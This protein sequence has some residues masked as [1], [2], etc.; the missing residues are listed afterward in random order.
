M[1]F[2]ANFSENTTVTENRPTFVKVVNECTVAQLFDS[3]CTCMY[4]HT[5]FSFSL[6]TLFGAAVFLNIVTM[7]DSHD[8]IKVID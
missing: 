8:G 5:Y 6:A 1:D 7:C 4:I 3:R 2:V